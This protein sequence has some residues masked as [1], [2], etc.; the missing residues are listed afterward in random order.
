V[1]VSGVHHVS[2]MV[3]DVPAARSFYVDVLGL[4]ERADRPDFAF[5]G[6]WL[7]AGSQQVHLVE[8]EVPDDRGQHVALH[9]ADLDAA[10][11]ELRAR[12]L[13]VSDPSPVGTSRQSFLRDPCGN[14]VEL[15]QPG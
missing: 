8:G 1:L 10:V 11:A 3:D 7:D 2:L 6:A 4:H 15:H 13:K 12:G 14:R 5:G 9:V